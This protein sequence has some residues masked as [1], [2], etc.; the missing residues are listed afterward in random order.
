MDNLAKF[1]NKWVDKFNN[2]S[3]E[4]GLY[5]LELTASSFLECTGLTL[6]I[7]PILYTRA[8]LNEIGHQNHIH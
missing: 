7:V 5:V 8:L 3:S 4:G 2:M 1:D 6:I